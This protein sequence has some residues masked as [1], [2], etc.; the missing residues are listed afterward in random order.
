M[1][2]CPVLWYTGEPTI[3]LQDKCHSCSPGIRF[4]DSVDRLPCA[5]SF[6]EFQ[7]GLLQGKFA[8]K[9]IQKIRLKPWNIHT[10][11]AKHWTGHQVTAEHGI[12][13]AHTVWP[14]NI[15]KM[16]F[17]SSVLK[18]DQEQQH[19]NFCNVI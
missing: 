18:Q 19:A 15:W 8:G 1:H 5:M 3:F 9:N 17:F 7:F 11:P 16:P 12:T 4:L 6:I 14:F 13:S 2:C 10:L